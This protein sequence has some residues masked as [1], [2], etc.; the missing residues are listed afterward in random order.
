MH[1]RPENPKALPL[2]DAPTGVAR[3]LRIGAADV[4]MDS[5]DF[6]RV[7]AVERQLA[8]LAG[9][10][11]RVQHAPNARDGDQQHEGNGETASQHSRC[12]LATTAWKSKRLVSTAREQ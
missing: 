8:T 6:Q 5:A 12:L 4:D 2:G 7:R 9:L 1:L 11:L 3:A 10:E